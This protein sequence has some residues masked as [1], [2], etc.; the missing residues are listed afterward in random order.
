MLHSR[1]SVTSILGPSGHVL[2][3]AMLED[4]KLCAVQ[5]LQLSLFLSGYASLQPM[6]LQG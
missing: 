1:G 3:P 5:D 4:A 2:S 6:S